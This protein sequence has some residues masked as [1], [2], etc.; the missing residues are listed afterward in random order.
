ML[1]REFACNFQ[2]CKLT[3]KIDSFNILTEVLPREF[4]CNFQACKLTHNIEQNIYMCLLGKL[5][6]TSFLAKWPCD[7]RKHDWTHS[8]IF[9]KLYPRCLLKYVPEFIGSR[10]I[11]RSKASD[12]LMFSLICAWINDWVNNREAGDLRCNRV[13]YDVIVMVC[14]CIVSQYMMPSNTV[15]CQNLCSQHLCLS[16]CGVSNQW[17]CQYCNMI[18]WGRTY[19]LTIW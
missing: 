15:V 1:P 11:P 12:V 5:Q 7:I 13:N 8:F 3:H 9:M 18:T 16:D 2:A 10:W 14:D 17:N 4:A 6:R 19:R